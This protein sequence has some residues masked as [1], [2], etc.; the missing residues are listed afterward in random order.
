[1][2]WK[3]KAK[4]TNEIKGELAA[5]EKAIPRTAERTKEDVEWE[6]FQRQG[7]IKVE[8]VQTE[9]DVILG[10]WFEECRKC[11]EKSQG[12]TAIKQVNE[13]RSALV[14]HCSGYYHC[15]CG[16]YDELKEI[17]GEG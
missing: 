9:I 2:S 7:W 3:S 13:A 16:S 1:M 6:E 8:D 5:K 4:T 10:K 17:L 12:T 14:G 15:K 11:Q